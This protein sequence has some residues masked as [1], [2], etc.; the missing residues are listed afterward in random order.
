[1]CDSSVPPHPLY[2]LREPASLGVAVGLQDS[3]GGGGGGRRASV[4]SVSPLSLAGSHLAPWGPSSALSECLTSLSLFPPLA[5]SVLITH[6]CIC[7]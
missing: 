4:F 3:G 2:L 6:L 1:M 5:A 7:F